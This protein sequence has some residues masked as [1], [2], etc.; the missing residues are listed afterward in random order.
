MDELDVNLER[1]VLADG[2]VICRA[3]KYARVEELPTADEKRVVA[4][5]HQCQET[6]DDIVDPYS[7]ES[8]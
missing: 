7:L 4:A 3:S 5:V 1:R 2:N 8:L 6:P